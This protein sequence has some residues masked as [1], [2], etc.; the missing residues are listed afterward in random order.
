MGCAIAIGIASA[1]QAIF[2]TT[3]A[4]GPLGLEIQGPQVALVSIAILDAL[5]GLA[6]GLFVSSFAKTEFQAIQFAP[7]ILLLQ[8]LLS[9]LLTSRNSYPPIGSH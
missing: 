8:L 4:I 6:L 7:A 2:V 3:Y 1:V 9:G 5:L